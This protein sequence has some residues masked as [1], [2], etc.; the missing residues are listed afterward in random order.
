MYDTRKTLLIMNEFKGRSVTVHDGNFEKA[1]RKFKKKI[2][3]AGV[4]M[5]VRE[6]E[7][8]TKPSVARKLAKA[9]AKRRWQKQVNKS[10][11]KKR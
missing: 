11:P 1:L 3:T 6:R 9:M 8:F 10:A 4:L 2:Q 5:D 7:T